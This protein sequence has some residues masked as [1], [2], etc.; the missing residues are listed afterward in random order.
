MLIVIVASINIGMAVWMAGLMR[1]T[2]R[3]RL[4]CSF[5]ISHE[6]D[7]FLCNFVQILIYRG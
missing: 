7:N 3:G 1:W 4:L 2:E 5:A 6:L